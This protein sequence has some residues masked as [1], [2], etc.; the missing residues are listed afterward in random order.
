MKQALARLRALAGNT[1]LRWLAW[2]LALHLPITCGDHW[3][4]PDVLCLSGEWCVVIALGAWAGQRPR[5]SVAVGCT[6]T[7]LFVLESV[8]LAGQLLTGADPQIYD[9]AFLTRHL[10]VLLLDLWG[11]ARLAAALVGLVLLI[12]GLCAL[13]S[14][15][16]RAV[17]VHARSLRLSS[18]LVVVCLALSL[19]PGELG[20]RWVT[21]ALVANAVDSWRTWRLTQASVAVDHYAPL[22][23][24]EP[25]A[26]RPDIG[27][28][29]VESYGRVLDDEPVLRASWHPLTQELGAELASEGWH[30]ASGWATAP[31]SGGRSWISDASVMLGIS[32]RHQSSWAHIQPK[33]DALTH[34][35]GWLK[36]HGG[37]QTVVCRPKDRA[38]LGIELRND[39]DWQ[40]TVF[41]ADIPYDGPA[42]GW[43]EIPDQFSLGHLHTAVLPELEG[44]RF[45]FFHG[46]SAHAPWDTPPPLVDRWQDVG[47]AVQAALGEDEEPEADEPESAKR[48]LKVQARRY[49]PKTGKRFKLPAR[50]FP[51]KRRAYMNVVDYSLRATLG[52]MA[53]LPDTPRGRLVVIYGDH[54]PPILPPTG[55]YDVP[56]HVLATDPRWLEP[57][58]E[59]GF[60]DGLA[61]ESEAEAMPLQALFPTVAA[62]VMGRELPEVPRG[63]SLTDLLEPTQP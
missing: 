5:A 34:L 26:A 57:F 19:M 21:P 15:R 30:V 23:A 52:A 50:L 62:A 7:L 22:M 41:A 2:G 40:H 32:I 51:E 42:V 20:A 1:Q 35:P 56:V 11:P 24:M 17:L 28:Y 25:P 6:W 36:E 4:W 16:L 55:A 48:A 39:F 54:Q 3:D 13:A 61:P 33:V 14:W 49:A 18:V 38:R 29:V 58:R 10:W 43:G 8:R 59:A 53:L 31:V 9:L 46:V 63:V 60:V 45:L 47:P 44:P 27:L 37:Y 12:A